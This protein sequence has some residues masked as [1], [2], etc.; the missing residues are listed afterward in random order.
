MQA[1][2]PAACP[3]TRAGLRPAAITR[4]DPLLVARRHV[5]FLRIRSAI[6]P[7]AR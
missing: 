2:G 1:V 5:D 3:S 4:T 7:T 6:C